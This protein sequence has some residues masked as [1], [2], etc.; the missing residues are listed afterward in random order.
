MKLIP[1][2]RRNLIDFDERLDNFHNRLDDLFYGNIMGENLRMDTFKLD[3]EEKKQQ[4]VVSAE[5]PGINKDEIDIEINND[6]LTI[7]VERKTE[8]DVEEKNYIHKERRFSSMQR[9][10]YLNDIDEGEIEAN[11]TD[12]VLTIAIPKKPTKKEETQKIEIK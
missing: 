5:M 8:T 9:S 10:V 12:G 3:I 2:R 11:L 1:F 6:R 4:Y 7:T